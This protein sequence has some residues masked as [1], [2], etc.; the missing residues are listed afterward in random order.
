MSR[1]R[2][3]GWNSERIYQ[4]WIEVRELKNGAIRILP[5][6]AFR[7][8]S[9]AKRCETPPA[10]EE[11]L[12]IED[13]AATIEVKSFEELVAELRRKYPDSEYERTVHMKRDR[14]AEVRGDEAMNGFIEIIAQSTVKDLL[15]RNDGRDP[16]PIAEL[17]GRCRSK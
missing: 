7:R 11:I 8:I 4:Y 14:E 1:A 16:L 9:L 2:S 13:G 10:T 17:K 12:R 3:F 5:L 15:R 6:K